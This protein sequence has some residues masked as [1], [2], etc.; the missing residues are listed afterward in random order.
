MSWQPLW[1][2][3]TAKEKYVQ[4]LIHLSADLARQLGVMLENYQ[5]GTWT[6][7]LLFDTLKMIHDAI[8]VELLM[9]RQ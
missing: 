5:N 7:V 2:L 3:K 4:R 8:E 1:V 9:N 6:E